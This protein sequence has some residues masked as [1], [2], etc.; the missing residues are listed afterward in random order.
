MK[1]VHIPKPIN[2]TITLEEILGYTVLQWRTFADGRMEVDLD[3][4]SLTA[5]EENLIIQK[6]AKDHYP[7][8]AIHEY[9]GGDELTQATPNLTTNDTW[10]GITTSLVAGESLILGEAVYLNPVDG[11]VWKS[12][13]A[14]RATMPSIALATGNS[15]FLLL[16]FMRHDAW[17][18]NTGGL[19]YVCRTNAGELTQDTPSI[20]G[21][22]VQVV[23]V[24]FTPTII[25]YNPSY[26]LVEIS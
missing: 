4:G 12:L 23:G 8:H 7:H 1:T 13:A 10:A 9:G 2:N 24:A 15:R 25:L 20:S 26:E 21:D 19:L 6:M 17:E 3:V 5:E 22:Q 16:G 14:S 18:W 11:K